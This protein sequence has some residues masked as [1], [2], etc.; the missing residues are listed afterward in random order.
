MDARAVA[1]GRLDRRALAAYGV[2]GLPLAMVA[3]PLYVHLPAFYADTQG[4][5]LSTVGV[6]LLLAR[7]AD[8]L[9]DPVIG[10]ASD[11][12]TDRR[13]YVAAGVPLLA[14]GMLAL[15]H[16]PD[17]REW[18]AAWLAAT[19]SLTYLGYSL[20]S[21]AY[22]AWGAELAR[23]PH[24]RTRVTAAREGFALTGVVIAALVPSAMGASGAAWLFVAV[25]VAGAATLLV[26]AP[27]PRPRRDPHPNSRDAGTLAAALGAAFANRAFRHLAL[28]FLASGIAA[29][30]PSTL[31]VFFVSDVLAA[32]DR[33]GAFLAIYFVAAALG[34]PLWVALARRRG[35]PYAWLAGMA[36]SVLAFVWAYGLGAGDALAF[37]GV[38]VVSGVALGADLALPASILA[39]VIDRDRRG[40]HAATEG[41]YFGLWNL[42]TKAN[43]ALA[44]GVALPLV[45]ALGYRPGGTAG[46]EALALVYSLVPCA[47]KVLAAI[48]LWR[49]RHALAPSSPNG[50]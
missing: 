43:L 3:L 5:A 35:K 9:S 47:L 16:P 10:H 12:A 28:V 34:L 31:V 21:I 4:L 27:R 1:A 36:L 37:A 29:A 30:I 15:F 26:L 13:G 6:V 8:A 14:V 19:V 49:A 22:T 44:A 41:G 18:G 20:A 33:L 42:L 11:R 45:S 7:L 2:F 48:A 23:A 17:S 40:P 38:C 25:L 50:G 39:D 32:P 24:E 46:L